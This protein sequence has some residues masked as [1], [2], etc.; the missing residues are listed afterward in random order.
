MIVAR[1]LSLFHRQFVIQRAAFV[2]PGLVLSIAMVASS[3]VNAETRPNVVLIISDDQGAGD[4]GFMGHP[5]IQTPNID[6][7]AKESL[8]FTRGF[9][10][11][12]VCCPSLATI[13]TGLYPHQHKITA[14]DPPLPEVA[15]A[16]PKGGRGSSP[17]LTT[18]WNA[19]LDEVLTLP[20]LLASR[21]YFSFQTG[22]WWQGDFSR[23]VFTHGMTDGSR[24][25]DKCIKIGLEGL[26][27]IFYFIAESR[28]RE[29]PFFVWYAPFMPH[30]P[31]N[32]PERLFAKYANKTDSPH[33]ARYWA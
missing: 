1:I 28:Q 3:T 11:T 24:H 21:S 12:S 25:C 14:N 30:S 5:H 15:D 16:K 26:Q 7:L 4:Y 17:E 2:L 18:Q 19:M 8:T 9:V 31:H 13:I 10:P 20:R 32:P 6:K 22:T 23:G 29:K 33:V 27:P